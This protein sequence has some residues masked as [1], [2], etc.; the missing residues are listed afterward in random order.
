[1]VINKPDSF[2]TE[3]GEK[4]NE[5]LNVIQENN[6]NYKMTVSIGYALCIEAGEKAESALLRADHVLYINKKQWHRCKN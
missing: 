5:E 2:A 6:K 1:M 3:V 4:I